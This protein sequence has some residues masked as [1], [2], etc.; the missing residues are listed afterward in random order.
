MAEVSYS[1][2]IIVIGAGPAGLAAALW[3][4]R[5]GAAVTI[6][7]RDPEGPPTTS[8][9]ALD[10]WNRPGVPQWGNGHAFHGLG[11]RILRERAGDVLTSLASVGV[12]ER[13]FNYHLT[14]HRRGDEDLVALQSRRPVFE[15]VLRRT[16]EAEPTIHVLTG[17]GVTALRRDRAGI[18]GANLANGT[19]LCLR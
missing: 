7:E 12:G 17:H 13:R 10:G 16:V 9:E 8:D 19:G 4:A 3:L 6:I 1:A 14:E 15:W 2:D 11:R 5:S 18:T